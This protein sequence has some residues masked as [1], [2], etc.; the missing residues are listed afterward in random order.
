MFMF[1]PSGDVM[2]CFENQ[3]FVDY[4]RLAPIF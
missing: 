1:G 2:A 4:A 3:V